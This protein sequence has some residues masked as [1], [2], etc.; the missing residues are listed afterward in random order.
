LKIL[1]EETNEG[2]QKWIKD[3][4]ITSLNLRNFKAQ[5]VVSLTNYFM[6]KMLINPEKQAHQLLHLLA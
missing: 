2:T 1:R 3:S 5:E 6:Q 4:K